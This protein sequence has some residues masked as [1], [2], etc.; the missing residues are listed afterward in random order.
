MTRLE[1]AET[2]ISL[3][4]AALL[5]Q[6]QFPALALSRHWQRKGGQMRWRSSDYSVAT[7]GPNTRRAERVLPLLAVIAT[8]GACYAAVSGTNDKVG[9]SFEKS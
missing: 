4:A 3:E 6:R 1:D 7:G 2:D 9:T 8:R 5:I